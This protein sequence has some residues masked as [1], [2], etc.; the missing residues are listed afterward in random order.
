MQTA[1]LDGLLSASAADVLERM[2]FTAPFE[3]TETADGSAPHGNWI[4][5]RLNFNG[6][7][8]GSFGTGMPPE[9]ARGLASAF[10]GA[11]PE[12]LD[13]PQVAEVV[14]E[15]A[16]MFCGSLLSRFDRDTR[17]LLSSPEIEAP[18]AVRPEPVS[19]RRL[20]QL[21]EGPVEIWLHLEQDRE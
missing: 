5:A 12:E 2:F 14:C 1:E 18:G 7:Q 9:T 4:S 16:N 21:E 20:F 10:L 13:P 11:E 3:E 8:R 19:A 15:L 17:F 6:Q